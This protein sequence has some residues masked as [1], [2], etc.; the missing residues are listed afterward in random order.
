GSPALQRGWPAWN[1]WA[2][3][4]MPTRGIIVM[5]FSGDLE[6]GGLG[7]VGDLRRQSEVQ[8]VRHLEGHRVTLDDM[9]RLAEALHERRIVGR[10][11]RL[12]RGQGEMLLVSAAKQ[13]Q[14]ETLRSLNGAEGR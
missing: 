3:V 2:S 12:F 13:R 11:G 8:G 4:A 5:S 6:F 9:H 1:W 14:P 10:V 7:L